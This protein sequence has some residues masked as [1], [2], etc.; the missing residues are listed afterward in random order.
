M[1]TYEAFVS[2]HLV[3]TLN[4]LPTEI[5]AQI[6]YTAHGFVSRMFERQ[7]NS[8]V[9][10]NA[11]DFLD[12]TGWT[13]FAQKHS[14]KSNGFDKIQIDCLLHVHVPET[15]TG[16]FDQDMGILQPNSSYIKSNQIPSDPSIKQFAISPDKELPGTPTIDATKSNAYAIFEICLDKNRFIVKLIQLERVLAVLLYKCREEASDPSLEIY[17]IVAL[18]GLAFPSINPDLVR[19]QIEINRESLSLIHQLYLLN[20]FS[21]YQKKWS[22]DGDDYVDTLS[23]I[24]AQMKKLDLK[25]RQ[26]NIEYQDQL[27]KLELQQKKA[28]MELE[29]EQKREEMKLELQQKKKEMELGKEEMELE[30]QRKKEEMETDKLIRRIMTAESQGMERVVKELKARLEALLLSDQ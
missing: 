29:L 28:E 21:V 4:S 6:D 5:T 11:T 8:T 24:S 17:N 19:S 14:K 1:T 18:A 7:H 25:E 9:F 20:R 22:N 27:R 16:K 3:T 10:K 13:A 30:K 12:G 23:Q 15:S 2:E 26:T